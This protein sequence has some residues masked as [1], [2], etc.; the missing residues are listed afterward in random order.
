MTKSNYIILG[1]GAS[2]LLL[3]YRMAND[4]FFDDKTIVIIDKTKDKG[5]DRTWC[6]WESARGEWDDILH[7]EWKTIYFG[8]DYYSKKNDISPYTYKMLRSESFYKKLWHTINEKSN[9]SFRQAE[10]TSIDSMEYGALITTKSESFEAS[11]VFNSLMLTETYKTQSQYPVLQQHFIGWFIK[12]ETH[13][14]DDG[15]ATFMDFKIP[16]NG[17]TRFMYILPTSK[18]EALFEYT[19]FSKDLL[20]KQEYENAIKNYLDNK[21]IKN[22]S[23]I[24]T[25][26][27]AIPMTCYEFSKQNSEHILNIGTAGGWTKA[28]TGY[29]FMN[30][31]KKT[32]ALVEFLKTES[33]VSKFSTRNKFWYYDLLMLDVLAEDNSY[34]SKL[35]SSLFKNTKTTTI[36]KFL[37]EETSLTEDLKILISVPTLRFSKTLF[38]RLFGVDKLKSN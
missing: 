37:D 21:G 24:E 35:F 11:K 1:A 2:G 16:Q 6:F 34:G 8:S 36:L 7:K 19:L 28:S 12:T 10:V 33:N 27:G 3:A 30:T 13:Q 29:T 15:V 22:Y 25:E 20:E 31:T 38:K 17:N 5:N 18:T 32:K 14:F 23:I 4:R 26:M 9:I